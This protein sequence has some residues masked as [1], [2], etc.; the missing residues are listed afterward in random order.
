MGTETQERDSNDT[1]TFIHRMI[2]DL[3]GYDLGH[4]VEDSTP[5]QGEETDALE[6]R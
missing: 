2:W 6:T 4:E 1:S 3:L 5:W